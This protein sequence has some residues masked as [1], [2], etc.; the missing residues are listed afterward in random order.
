MEQGRGPQYEE[1]VQL[2]KVPLKFSEREICMIIIKNLTE[3]VKY[4]NV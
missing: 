1:I 4:Q 2:Q 3:L